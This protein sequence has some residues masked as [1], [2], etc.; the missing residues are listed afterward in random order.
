MDAV[1]LATGA[2]SARAALMGHPGRPFLVIGVGSSPELLGNPGCVNPSSPF[3]DPTHGCWYLERFLSL[4]VL[5]QDPCP[6]GTLGSGGGSRCIWGVNAI[7]VV[8]CAVQGVGT[9]LRPG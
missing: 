2:C 6:Q 1:V 9:S 5:S 8:P 7:N 4:Y 3:T